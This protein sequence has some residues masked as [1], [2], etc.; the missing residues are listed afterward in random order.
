V[1]RS[2]LFR[3]LVVVASAAILFTTIA[4]VLSFIR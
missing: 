2:V 3:F 4:I 1:G